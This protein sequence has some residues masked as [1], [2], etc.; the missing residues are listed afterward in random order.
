MDIHQLYQEFVNKVP[1]IELD[2]RELMDRNAPNKSTRI[3]LGESS[4]VLN[5]N[6]VRFPWSYGLYK[7]FLGNF[8]TPFEINMQADKKDFPLLT[9]EQQDT[10][11][12]IIGLLSF[13]DSMQSDYSADISKHL[14]DS[15]LNALMI[16]LAQQEVI[17]NQSYS[18]ILASVEQTKEAQDKV[19]EFWKHDEV[20]INRN[21]F[22]VNGYKPQV[23]H[24]TITD[25]LV[26]IIYDVV[27]E[28]LFFYSGFAFFYDLARHGK[29]VASATMINYI[30]RDEQQHVRL[31]TEIFKAI[32]QDF[33]EYDVPELKALTTAIFKKAAELET[34]WSHYIIGTRF[35]T[36][37]VDELAGYIRF[38]A[39]VRT[40]QLGAEPPFLRQETNPM[41]W[42]KVY[43]ETD[44]GK[45]DFFEQKSRAYTKTDDTFDDTEDIDLGG[46][47]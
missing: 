7:K 24:P 30:N 28:G 22:I 12:K 44:L 19:F 13:L 27:L 9:E 47:L 33:P 45:T 3:L 41:E 25:M 1:H 5:W 46:L 17:H 38:I 4:N 6:D 14:T 39:N 20:L 37:D 34:T 11:L 2:R 21:D 16:M 42:I 35:P 32:K 23:K 15:S 18:Y 31:F 40:K 29:M 36:I 10:F 26:S 8:W 43:A